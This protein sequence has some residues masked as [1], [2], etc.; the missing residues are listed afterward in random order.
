LTEWGQADKRGRLVRVDCP[1]CGWFSGTD[2]DGCCPRCGRDVSWV[3][4]HCR[5]Y[6]CNR[7]SRAHWYLVVAEAAREY[8]KA[9]A[10]PALR[11]ICK[12]KRLT[13]RLRDFVLDISAGNGL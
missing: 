6:L 7:I 9:Y 2:E 1:V 12:T 3:Y 13:R 10:T 11:E 5:I 8:G 4:D